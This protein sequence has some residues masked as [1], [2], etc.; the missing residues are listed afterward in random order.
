MVL[1]NL[2]FLLRFFFILFFI[3]NTFLYINDHRLGIFSIDVLLYI[4]YIFILLKFPAYLC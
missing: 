4:Q 1:Q 3:T 2:T